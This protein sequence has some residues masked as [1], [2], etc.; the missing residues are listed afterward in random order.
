MQ[1]EDIQCLAS[2]PCLQDLDFVDE[3]FS[4]T[5]LLSQITALTTLTIRQIRPHLHVRYTGGSDDAVYASMY[6]MELSLLPRL[7]SLRLEFEE[8]LIRPLPKTATEGDI[9][10]LWIP[11][12]AQH[13]Q[14]VGRLSLILLLR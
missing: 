6:V 14:Q 7:D 10:T 2:L 13:L 3:A 12:I 11:L 5:I 4:S 9:R 1:E 8:R